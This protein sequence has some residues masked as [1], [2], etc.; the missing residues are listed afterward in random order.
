MAGLIRLLFLFP[1]LLLSVFTDMRDQP[2]R[3]YP[4]SGIAVTLPAGTWQKKADLPT[5]R[6]DYGAAVH[7]DKFYIIGGLVLPSPWFPTRRVDVYDPKTNNWTRIKDYPKLVHHIGV[8]SCDG[9][10]YGIAGYRIRIFP[11]NDV[12]QYDEGKNEWIKRTSIPIA[13]GAL[14][15]TCVDDHIYAIGGMDHDGQLS[16]L[17]VYDT[18]SD[19]WTQKKEMP[20]AREHLA[21]VSLGK[22]IYVIGGLQHNRYNSLTTNEVY[23]TTT[24]TW[25]TLA[26]LPHAINGFGAAVIGESIYVFGGARGD[27]ITKEVFEYNTQKNVWTRRADIPTGRYGYAIG[28]LQNEAHIVGGNTIVKGNFFSRDHDVFTP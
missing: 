1:F 18:K 10:L 3:I 22:R 9:K 27:A 8:V 23:D 12:Y 21:V 4:D 28:V 13:R 20:T 19:A 11:T 6:Y 16:S 15:V 14:G 7:N 5:E 25:E 2:E 26:P 24:D 17:A